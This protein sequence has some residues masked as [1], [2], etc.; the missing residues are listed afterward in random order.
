GSNRR[1]S[2]QAWTRFLK[3]RFEIVSKKLV[4][5]VGIE[6]TTFPASLDAL[7]KEPIRNCEQEIGGPGRD[8]TDDLFHAMEARSQLRHRPTVG[9][10]GSD[11]EGRTRSCHY[12]RRSTNS[13]SNLMPFLYI[14][15]STSTLR[16]YTGT[17]EEVEARVTEH[18]R[19]Q[20]PSTR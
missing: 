13:T 8:R 17:A 7:L 9:E 3:S 19:G 16:F 20:T 11:A 1:P 2:R 14:L 10:F 18:N 12:F 15:Q 5:L 6:P 4:D